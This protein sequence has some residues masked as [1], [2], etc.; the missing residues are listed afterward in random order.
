MAETIHLSVNGALGRMGRFVLQ[1][2]NQDQG[3]TIQEALVESGSP[4]AGKPLSSFLSLPTLQE[5]IKLQKSHQA[6]SDVMVDFSLPQGFRTRLQEC[7]QHG[8][9]LVSGTTGLEEKDYQAMEAASKEI[10]VLHAPNFSI[11]VNLLYKLVASA[12]KALQ[13]YDIEVSEIHHRKKK[14]APSGTAHGLIEKIQAATSPAEHL[15]LVHGREQGDQERSPD[16]LGVHALRGGDVVG[17][18]TVFFF[19][20]GERVE[21]THRASSRSAFAAGALS[22]AKVLAQKPPGLYTLDQLLF[23]S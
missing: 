6:G 14:D 5:E 21:L 10:A 22:A 12:T 23:E 3:F 2:A 1:L 11:G 16:E 17:E 4:D 15:R 7:L 13:G 18:H 8:T 19:G 20:E 9:A